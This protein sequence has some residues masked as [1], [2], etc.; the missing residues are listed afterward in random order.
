MTMGLVLLFFA[1]NPANSATF[2]SRLVLLADQASVSKLK[3]HGAVAL[4]RRHKDVIE[5]LQQVA[6]R[7]QIPVI[8]VLERLVTTGEVASYT[9]LF[10]ANAV[11]VR[12]TDAAFAELETLPGVAEVIED[13]PFNVIQ[14][15]LRHGVSSLD[16]VAEPGL[17]SIRAREVWDMGITGAGVLL[18]NLDTGVNGAHPALSG[19][20]LGSYGYPSAACWL[21]LA[22]TTSSPTDGVGHGTMTM[23]ILC[24]GAPG[25]T[26]GVA[27]GARYIAARLNS[28][29]SAVI[30]SALQA[31][32]WA[33]DPDGNPA[34]FSDVP[35]VI[36]NSWGLVASSYPP[37]YDVFNTALDNCEA[38]GIAIFWAAGNEGAFGGQTIGVPAQR[39]QAETSEFAVGGY[40]R[41][42]DSIWTQSSRGPSPCTANPSFAIKPEVVAPGRDIRSANGSGY[43]TGS[44]T[45]FAA[46]HAAGTAALML[47]ANPGLSPDSLKKILLWTAV[48]KGPQGNDNTYGYGQ[49]DAYLAVMGALGG[50]G[51]IRGQITDLFGDDVAAPVT[52]DGHP[53]HV[54]ADSAGRFL[55]AMPAEMPFALRIVYPSFQTWVQTEV[56]TARDTLNLNV[57]LTLADTC[58][59]LT[60]TVTNCSGWPAANARVWTQNVNIPEVRTD[61]QGRFHLILSHGTY[62]IYA[63]DGFC[64][65]ALM[66][67]VQILGGGIIDVELVLPNN[68]RHLPSPADPYGYRAYD[69]TDPGGPVYAWWEIS[70]TLGGPGVMHN[71]SDDG[72][73]PLALPFP[74]KFYGV[75]WNR[76]YLNANGSVSF[77]RGFTAY[78]NAS[79]PRYWAPTIYPFWDDL[80]D[81]QGGDICSYYE[82]A[83]GAFIIEWSDVPHHNLGSSESFEVIIYDPTLFPTANGDATIEVRYHDVSAPN[84]ATIGIEAASGNN[85]IQYGYNGTFAETSSLLEPGRAIRYRPGALSQGIPALSVLNLETRL[86][87]APGQSVD[88]AL[89]LVNG[90]SAP[91]AYAVLIPGETPSAAYEW[92]SIPFEFN[93]IDGMGGNI[94]LIEDDTTSDPQLLPW[95][96]PFFERWFDRATISSNG[97]LSFTS[98]IDDLSWYVFPVT[99]LHDPYYLLAPYWV[100]LNIERGGQVKTLYDSLR[101]CYVVQWDSLHR[102]SNDTGPN[103][104]QIVLW[105]DGAI[106]FV[107]AGMTAPLNQGTVGIKGRQNEYLQLAYNQTFITSNLRVRFSRPDTA[108]TRCTARGAR[109]GIVPA[110]GNVR[111]P[112]R[113]TNRDLAW[114]ESM[115]PVEVA[116][117]GAGGLRLSAQF[118][119]WSAPDPQQMN[120]VLSPADSGVVLAW[121]PMPGMHYC[122]YSGTTIA[123]CNTFETC[124]SDTSVFIAQTEA[125]IRYFEVRYCDGPPAGAARN[126]ETGGSHDE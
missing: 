72:V 58:G 122:V 125:P 105:R 86:S 97:F 25:D 40:D 43:A 46:P 106:D 77:N 69:D 73:V 78:T 66:A 12:G 53:Q 117:S 62:T 34:T 4:R 111:V 9:P 84:S 49:I 118:S 114:G 1:A 107:Y 38:A 100:D 41:V 10:I 82:P 74:V 76:I 68:P 18:A 50:V 88:T 27:W 80:N 23:G 17:V 109:Q 59:A 71:M 124:V 70:P 28:S 65:D 101:D 24:G 123:E 19:R 33:L 45:S 98:C 90:G 36:S 42:V 121:S 57:T 103:T 15:P 89:V 81:N 104:F 87:V 32:Q 96:F 7:S 47:E 51:W 35:R 91:A 83:E 39:A 6:T 56:L 67:G 112:L 20:W 95:H 79:L 30:S 55:I 64:A 108:A 37:C 75:T 119:L 13:G 93:S 26:V 120:V 85:Y 29:G 31:L 48:D 16:L 21:D 2:E 115:W 5:G 11:A 3:G 126:G 14:E 116:V 60:G 99:D 52:I 61:T 22:G 54:Q 102:F 8:A 92:N 110:G 113:L 44:G 94:G 63:S